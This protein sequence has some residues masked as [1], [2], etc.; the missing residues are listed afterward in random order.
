MNIWMLFSL[1]LSNPRN[2]FNY[3]IP[4]AYYLRMNWRR[5]MFLQCVNIQKCICRNTCSFILFPNPRAFQGVFTLCVIHCIRAFAVKSETRARRSLRG[6][7][8]KRENRLRKRIICYAWLAA[9]WTKI[10]VETRVVCV[11]KRRWRK[12]K[13]GK[14]LGPAKNKKEKL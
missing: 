13:L 7:C 9:D 4:K 8:R 3:S 10:V 1:P 6:V 11:V 14:K 5:L 2:I 12:Y